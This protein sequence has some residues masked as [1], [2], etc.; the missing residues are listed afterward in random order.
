MPPSLLID[1][2][3]LTSLAQ[4]SHSTKYR[5][6]FNRH[7]RNRHSRTNISQLP[8]PSFAQAHGL[9]RLKVFSQKIERIFANSLP[10]ADVV[11][12]G[13]GIPSDGFPE[14]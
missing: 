1:L 11:S 13:Q 5:G 9:F 14:E 8:I 10:A 3:Y 4:P 2:G 6:A 12:R 7:F